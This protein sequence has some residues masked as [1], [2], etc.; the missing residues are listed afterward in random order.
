MELGCARIRCAPLSAQGSVCSPKEMNNP[1]V[2]KLETE[3]NLWA[4]QSSDPQNRNRVPGGAVAPPADWQE[5]R[6][7]AEHGQAQART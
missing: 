1:I 5:G 6:T 3:V 4:L 7:S 2:S